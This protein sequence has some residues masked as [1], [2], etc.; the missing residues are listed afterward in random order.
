MPVTKKKIVFES[1]RVKGHDPRF[2]LSSAGTF[3][4]AQYQQTFGFLDEMRKL[5]N[6][7][8]GRELS[9]LK[10]KGQIDSEYANGLK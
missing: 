7:K 6:K 3:N 2:D 9:Q 1:S 10:K 4:P 5:E 8:F